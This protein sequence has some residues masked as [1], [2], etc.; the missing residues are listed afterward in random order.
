MTK[1]VKFR[2][3]GKTS[4]GGD[5]RAPLQDKSADRSFSQAE[6]SDLICAAADWIWETDESLRFS[7]VSDTY[8]AVTGFIRAL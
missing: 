1:T 2:Q 4:T 3:Y 5:M 7:W 6:T 8:E